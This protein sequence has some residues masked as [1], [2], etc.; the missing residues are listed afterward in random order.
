[1]ILIPPGFLPQ[2][3]LPQK[4]WLLSWP[5]A[6]HFKLGMPKNSQLS[7]GI[8]LC[9]QEPKMLYL[10]K[11]C[12]SRGSN[13]IFSRQFVHSGVEMLH[14]QGIC[15]FKPNNA[16]FLQSPS[17]ALRAASWFFSCA[18]TPPQLTP[19]PASQFRVVLGSISSR[20]VLLS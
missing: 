20:T 9:I 10:Q 15:A 19:L 12:A 3:F 4:F 14:F 1:M 7:G 11:A 5:R 18:P 16:A 13:A 17:L 8:F 6:H 2:K